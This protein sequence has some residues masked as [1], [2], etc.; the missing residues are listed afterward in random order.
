M[1]PVTAREV[2]ACQRLGIVE[3]QQPSG[4]KRP[5]RGI[6]LLPAESTWKDLSFSP[7]QMI[8]IF[9]PGFPIGFGKDTC[10]GPAS[11]SFL[12]N[13]S[14][15]A[16]CESP[17]IPD[18]FRRTGAKRIPVFASTY[19]AVLLKSRLTG[20]LRE[21]GEKKIMV[22]GVLVEVCGLGVLLTGESGIGKT[23][24]GLEITAWGHRWVADDAVVLER[25]EGSLFGR[26]HERTRNLI[27]TRSGGILR[28]E[29]LMKP[30]SV[31]EE[32][33]V[34]VVV[35][36]V[37]DFGESAESHGDRR[38]SV[39]EIMGVSLPCYQVRAGNKPRM[40]AEEVVGLVRGLN[41]SLN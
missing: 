2:L 31:A 8:V 32:T 17:G 30:E 3:T 34:N 38:R 20:L 5:V 40:V 39:K 27:A 29:A 35:Q 26:G 1:F 7:I 23:S 11:A 28:V 16:L 19:D 21:C 10:H 9:P 22:H 36:L 24:C 4:A 12:Q 37:R 18:F 33:Q 13:I 41:R 25:R 6:V 15:A 14:C